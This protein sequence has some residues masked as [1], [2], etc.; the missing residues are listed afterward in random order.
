[1]GFG[2]EARDFPIDLV[3]NVGEME[4]VIAEEDP[5]IWEASWNVGGGGNM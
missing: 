3:N 5:H 1:M 4:E 2:L